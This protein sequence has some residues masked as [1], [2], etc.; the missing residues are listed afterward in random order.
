MLHLTNSIGMR[1]SVLFDSEQDAFA[2]MRAL[3]HSG[4]T[5]N[6]IPAG[7]FKLPL[8]M[9]E[10]F[11]WSLIGAFSLTIEDEPGVMFQGQFYKRREYE[12][13]TKGK[14]LPAAIKYSRGAKPTDPPHLIEGDE[15]SSFKYVTL[16]SFRGN[17]KAI[18]Q[19]EIPGKDG[20]L[21]A[22]S[23]PQQGNAERPPIK[24]EQ[25]ADAIARGDAPGP[26]TTAMPDGMRR[27]IDVIIERNAI[28]ELTVCTVVQRCTN[29]RTMDYKKATAA[30]GAE[31]VKA[32]QQLQK[33]G[34][35]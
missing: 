19:F 25:L 9:H 17:G 29:T 1:V 5:P 21:A 23:K 20:A 16:I 8:A 31:I 10:R 13:Q 3:G 34:A 11:D 28:P 15:K 30:E 7:G 24:G 26:G 22:R 35:A 33:A 18:P 14:K 2:K 4:W 12:E 6:E 27:T 32:L